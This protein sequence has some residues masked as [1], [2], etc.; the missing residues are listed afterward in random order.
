MQGGGV[1]KNLT[2]K[3]KKIALV[4]G[5]AAVLA[6]IALLSRNKAAAAE[7]PL[8]ENDRRE[9]NELEAREAF[10]VPVAAGATDPTAFLGSQ[11]EDVTSA[12]GE[13]GSS[14]SGVAGGLEGLN[15]EVG[16]F[17][18]D[19]MEAANASQERE[20]AIAGQ[21]G[22]QSRQLAG[23]QKMLA[24][25]RAREQRQRQAKRQAQAKRKQK[26]GGRKAKKHPKRKPKKRR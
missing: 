15:Y 4:V 25:Q 2:P 24:G 17:R 13:V 10:G 11:S 12:L 3:Q 8:E 1:F 6:L 20:G 9:A 22:T 5:A 21:L 16:Q 26:A 23:V 14:L 18:D 7:S 19:S